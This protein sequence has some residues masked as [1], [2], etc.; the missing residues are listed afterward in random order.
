MEDRIDIERPDYYV[1]FP[2][3]APNGRGG[4]DTRLTTYLDNAATTQKP[5]IVL[6]A[7]EGF[8]RECNANP[9]RGAY[10]TSK[11]AT[12][13]Y[14]CSRQM[15]ADFIRAKHGEVVFTRNATEALNLVAYC[16]AAE[17]LKP[18]DKIALPIS[19][20]HSNLVPWQHV[21]RKTGAKL[22][23]LYPDAKGRLT[24]EE[25]EGKVDGSVRIVAMAHAS[26]VLGTVQPVTEITAHA[27]AQG[28]VVVL[29]CA[30]SVAHCPLDVKA[31]DVDFA[32]FSG[33]KMYG[34]MGIG[35]LY[36]KEALL[37]SM[38][39]FL[40]GGE[41]IDVVGDTRSTFEEGPKKYEAGTPNVAGAI[42]LA[43]AISY[44]LGIGFEE[45]ALIEKNLTEI[46]LEGLRSIEGIRIYGNPHA[47]HDRLGTV[48]FNIEGCNPQD[49]AA[50]LDE[51][52]IAIRSGSHC[53]QPLHRHLGIE[54]SCRVTPCFYNTPEDI[55]RFLEATQAVR[56][57]ISRRIMSLFP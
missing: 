34:P 20:H 40:F 23:Y 27:H 7:V 36:A 10:E 48:S 15:V 37:D 51:D 43:A 16:Y 4:G 39:P 21:C 29:D 5:S 9:Y 56:R 53:A 11:A 17:N 14:E 42:G 38:P 55:E 47:S 35:A 49:V 44:L 12:K 54:A 32:A 46:L 19:E 52:G 26:N 28:A 2:A 22:V 8:Y 45:I 57:K 3:V 41:M 50:M 33:H 31:L 25:V 18:G 1:D 6:E 13:L 24:K 30:Q